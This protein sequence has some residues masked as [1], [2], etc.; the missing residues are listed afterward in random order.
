M[1]AAWGGRC[2]EGEH[3]IWASSKAF[4]A[5]VYVLFFSVSCFSH[6]MSLS[7]FFL[8][9]FLSLTSTIKDF[10]THVYCINYIAQ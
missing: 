10:H 2:G 1:C 7:F 8:I 9:F 4:G 3:G 6:P 5:F